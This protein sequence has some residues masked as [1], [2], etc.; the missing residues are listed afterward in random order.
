MLELQPE[1]IWDE[2]VAILRFARREGRLPG[3]DARHR[4]TADSGL[5]ASRG[6]CGTGPS[7][8]NWK[9]N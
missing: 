2:E 7:G 6:L 1:A 5:W 4:L 8:E 9:K 3:F